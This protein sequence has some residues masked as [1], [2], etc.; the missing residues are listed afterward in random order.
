MSDN[1]LLALTPSEAEYAIKVNILANEV[2]L[3]L[4]K[5]GI[6]KSSLI[7]AVA[8]EL[9]YRV[10]D[11]RLSMCTVE[12]FLG[13]P[14]F[15][16]GKATFCPFDMW[17]VGNNQDKVILFLDEFTSA[18]KEIQAPAYRLVED[19][20]VG[21][22]KLGPN[23][24]I[25]CAG[26]RK[27]DRA[28]SNTL[29]TALLSRMDVLEMD[30]DSEEFIKNSPK[31]G[32]HPLVIGYLSMYPAHINDFN[33]DRDGISPF[34]C[35]RTWYKVSKVIPHFKNLGATEEK[36]VSGYIGSAKA[37]TFMGFAKNILKVEKPEVI[38]QNPLS[39]PIPTSRD[40]IYATLCTL[41]AQS[42]D[43]LEENAEAYAT[44]VDR[45][46]DHSMILLFYR[47]LYV[48]YPEML[49]NPD[50]QTHLI[51]YYKELKDIYSYDLK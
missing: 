14:N 6:G 19:R 37:H 12:D 31:W 34:A 21:Q 33:P 29:S 38:A 1:N 15:I 9:G 49:T 17:P 28:I 40:L 27:E 7:K 5:P 35:P 32:M 44:Y 10:I 4:G 18:P 2:T 20:E 8:K 16:N 43:D 47:M 13:L 22:Q 23:V 30:S 3:L 50:L 51:P 41:A 11:I 42:I 36:I 25:V 45:F 48:T 46:P 39:T 24:R 26:N